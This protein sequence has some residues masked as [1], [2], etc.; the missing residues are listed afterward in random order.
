MM[1]LICQRRKPVSGG[2][3]IS[4]RTCPIRIMRGVTVELAIMR[5]VQCLSEHG[6]LRIT[7]RRG[8]SRVA[9]VASFGLRKGTGRRVT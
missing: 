2:D 5:V 8:A 1:C 4:V 7:V 3:S 9:C 6:R